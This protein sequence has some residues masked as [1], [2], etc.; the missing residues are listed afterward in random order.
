MIKNELLSSL[1][2]YM[3][4]QAKESTNS[5]RRCVNHVS[6]NFII[7]G[8]DHLCCSI[9]V[10]TK[11]H[12]YMQSKS[13]INILLRKIHHIFW[14]KSGNFAHSA[15]GGQIIWFQTLLLTSG[16]KNLINLIFIP[17]CSET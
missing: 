5:N 4:Q 2:F 1:K 14:I 11:N 3:L 12:L 6:G 9:S 13:Y 10:P 7:R 15:F 16:G 8:L 17:Q